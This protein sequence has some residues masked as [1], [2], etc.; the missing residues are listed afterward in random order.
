[1]FRKIARKKINMKMTNNPS[2]S[3]IRDMNL[4]NR[5]K[6]DAIILALG[7]V[8]KKKPF[9]NVLFGMNNKTAIERQVEWLE[10]YVDKIIIAC[11]KKELKEIRKIIKSDKVVFSVEPFPLGTAGAVK[12]AMSLLK[13]ENFIVCNVDDITDIDLRALINFGANSIC[14][15]NPRLPYGML[16]IENH[17]IKNFREKPLM[18]N[19][20]VSC[21]V[22]FLNKSI[23]EKLPKRGSLEKDVFP[24]IHLKAYKHFGVWKTIPSNVHNIS[25]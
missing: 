4:T 23:E 6:V 12:K 14:V 1:M 17:V 7:A 5:T 3:V 19:I 22:Y 13:N 9:F 21:G 10:P 15:T 25:F 16:E 2:K 11:G 24:F 20:W 8:G 18:K